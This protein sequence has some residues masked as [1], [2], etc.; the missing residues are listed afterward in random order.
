MDNVYPMLLDLRSCF[1][2][3]SSKECIEE[4]K[5]TRKLNKFNMTL[6]LSQIFAMD[7]FVNIDIR[8]RTAFHEFHNCFSHLII[9]WSNELSWNAQMIT[10]RPVLMTTT[11]TIA[12]A[13]VTKKLAKKQKIGYLVITNLWRMWRIEPTSTTSESLSNFFSFKDAFLL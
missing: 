1:L 8:V 11:Q 10:G 6:F 12:T 4:R 7:I 3:M 2:L 13:R 9:W 5:L